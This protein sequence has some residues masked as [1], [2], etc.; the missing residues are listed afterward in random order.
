[1]IFFDVKIDRT[2][3]IKEPIMNATLQHITREEFETQV[4]K[5]KQPVLVDFWAGWCGP[6]RAQLP[7]LER[8]AGDYQDRLSVVKVNVDDEPQLAARFE[9]MSIPTMIIFHNGRPVERLVGVRTQDE[10]YSVFR[11]LKFL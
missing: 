2:V 11:Q 8:F 6:C 3:K 1:L 5:S 9:I 10:L 4:I 7:I